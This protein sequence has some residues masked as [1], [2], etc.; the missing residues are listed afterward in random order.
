MPRGCDDGTWQVVAQLVIDADC[1]AAR[2]P[3]A[4]WRRK[5]LVKIKVHAVKA[6]VAGLYYRQQRIHIRAVQVHQA[7]R[8]MHAVDD[9]Q[10]ARLE[11]PQRAGHGQHHAGDAPG[12]VATACR[13][14]GG[15]IDL[16]IVICWQL[17]DFHAGHA[18]CGGVRA[19][20]AVG[21]EDDVALAVAA[22]DVVA[23]DHEYAGE[24]ALRAGGWRQA[25]R[26]KAADFA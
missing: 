23:A 21:D 14:Q 19:M 11:E 9:L 8:A 16:A 26:L 3:A 5:G 10:N 17:Q 15:H 24:L 13:A 22:V 18:H 7:A 20:R 2:S 25:D 1:A 4:V 6:Q 12:F